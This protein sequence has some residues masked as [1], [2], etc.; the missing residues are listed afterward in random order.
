M[1]TTPTANGPNW[2]TVAMACASILFSVGLGVGG[3]FVA[4][5]TARDNR[6]DQV[7]DVVTTKLVDISI[8]MVSLKAGQ[9]ETKAMVT[10]EATIREERDRRELE[11]LRQRQSTTTPKEG[12]TKK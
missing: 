8:N 1:S 7:L 11:E 2:Q 9:E 6:Q 5:Q 12:A 3:Y 10:K 4:Q